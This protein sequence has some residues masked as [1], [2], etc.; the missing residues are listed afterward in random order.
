MKLKNI[1]KRR[2]TFEIGEYAKAWVWAETTEATLLFLNCGGNRIYVEI[3]EKQDLQCR[4]RYVDKIKMQM[5][6]QRDPSFIFPSWVPCRDLCHLAYDEQV[7]AALIDRK[8]S[9]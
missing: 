3:M 8:K 4:V 5:I 7:E 6:R 9:C 1:F 2:N